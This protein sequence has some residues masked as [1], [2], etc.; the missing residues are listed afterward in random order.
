[1]KPA[2]ELNK[3]EW[4]DILIAAATSKAGKVFT[5]NHAKTRMVERGITLTQAKNILAKGEFV[6]GPYQET[7]GSWKMKV[8]GH[9]S[10]QTISVVVS[11]QIPLV[12]TPV[13]IITVI[14]EDQAWR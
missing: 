3:S 7:D 4:K 6:E 14:N 10:A 1:M 9:D 8:K 12:G 2:E 5:T 13:I 11:I